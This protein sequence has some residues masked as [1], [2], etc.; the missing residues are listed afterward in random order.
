VLGSGYHL[1]NILV[2]LRE[3]D[4]DSEDNLR[5]DSRKRERH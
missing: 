1:N 3:V 2:K 4:D 5:E